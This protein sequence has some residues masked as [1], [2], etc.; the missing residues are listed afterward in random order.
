MKL[1]LLGLTA[2]AGVL[3]LAACGTISLGSQPTA[4]KCASVTAQL[5]MDTIL[6]NAASAELPVLQTTMDNTLAAANGDKTNKAYVGAQAAFAAAQAALP[7]LQAIL[8]ADQGT[9]A[10]QCA[11][12]SPAPASNAAPA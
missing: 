10:A 9:V 6:L 3:A 1:K 7:G 11:T 12:P 8:A 5:R 2:V 4:A